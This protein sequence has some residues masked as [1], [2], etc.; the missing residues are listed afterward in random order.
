VS[1]KRNSSN[2]QQVRSHGLAVVTLVM[3]G[4]FASALVY[5]KTSR[6][7]P[8]VPDNT[9]TAA[10][11]DAEQPT[12][13]RPKY[14]FYN[15]L[16]RR[17]LKIEPPQES[18][19]T[20]QPAAQQPPAQQTA[21]SEPPPARSEPPPARRESSPPPQQQA[22]AA[23]SRYVIQAGAY[24]LYSQADRAR[25]RL[26]MIGVNARIEEATSNG[27]PIYRIRIGPMSNA[28]ADSLRQRLRSNN[29]ESMALKVN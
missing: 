16:P 29:I 24:T 25:A 13:N 17:E 8:S 2:K 6:E 22:T 7:T 20:R 9:Q 14:E 5:I 10:R 11:A 23:G 21:R 3:I 12:E 15:E 19:Q 1:G 27:L 4:L 26:A 28:E 18:N